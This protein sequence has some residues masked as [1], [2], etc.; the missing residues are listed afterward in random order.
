MIQEFAIGVAKAAALNASMPQVIPATGVP[1]AMMV[2][3]S[4]YVP[5][6]FTGTGEPQMFLQEFRNWKGKWS[7][8]ERK[9]KDS[10]QVTDEVLQTQ[11]LNAMSGEARDSASA[12]PAGSYDKVMEQLT[13]KF[14]DSFRLA[15][16]YIP[17]TG[18]EAGTLKK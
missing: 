7:L 6:P 9:L 1:Q 14:G 2:D 3:V 10:P 18:G 13:A 11:L 17:A 5:V 4:K 12:L 16:S 15:S 8:A